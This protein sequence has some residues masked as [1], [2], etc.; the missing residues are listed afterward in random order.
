MADVAAQQHY[1][2]YRRPVAVKQ[3]T[4]EELGAHPEHVE[5]DGRVGGTT[6]R[7]V[8]GHSDPGGTNNDDGGE[9]VTVMDKLTK[10]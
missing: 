9:P 3:T 2:G 7:R 8:D 5:G 1:A 10:Q 4:R 6:E